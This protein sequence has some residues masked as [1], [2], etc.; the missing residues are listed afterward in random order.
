MSDEF[1][2]VVRGAVSVKSRKALAEM[3]RLAGEHGL[4]FTLNPGGGEFYRSDADDDW[5][6]QISDCDDVADLQKLRDALR[7]K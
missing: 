1:D 6:C 7:Q 2:D 3:R 4:R 5:R